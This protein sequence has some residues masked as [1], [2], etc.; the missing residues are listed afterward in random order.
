MGLFRGALGRDSY[1]A[2]LYGAEQ[3][4]GYVV[5]QGVGR[6]ERLYLEAASHRRFT[7]AQLLMCA[8]LIAP[9]WTSILPRV[10][11]LRMA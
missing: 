1:R 11:A 2:S 4:R 8:Y 3:P 9:T 10:Q 5:V 7:T 6:V